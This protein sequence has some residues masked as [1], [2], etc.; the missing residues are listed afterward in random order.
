MDEKKFLASFL[1]LIS[2]KIFSVHSETFKKKVS[3]FFLSQNGQKVYFASFSMKSSS[4]M[5][6][7][8]FFTF[9]PFLV[10]KNVDSFYLNVSE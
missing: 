2:K 9:S 7:K 3:T 4:K 10:K 5:T 6:Q 8:K 1:I